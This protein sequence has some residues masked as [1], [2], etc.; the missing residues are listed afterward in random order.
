M[1]EKFHFHKRLDVLHYGCEEPRA[2]FVPYHSESAAKTDNRAESRFFKTLCGE[3]DFHF[4]SS[5]LDLVDFTAPSCKVNYDKIPV[6][7][8]WQYLTDRGYDVPNYTNV[9]YPFP[10]DP[11]H[12][13]DNNPC[14][15]YHRTFTIS[16]SVLNTKDTFLVFE[17]VDSCFYVFVNNEFVAYSQVAHMT[18]E[19]DITPYIKHGT[20]DLKVLVFKWCD[21]SYLECQDKWR[22]SGIIREVYLLSRDKE[23][24]Q[25][26]FVKYELDDLYTT[27]HLTTDI[28]YIGSPDM[29]WTLTDVNNNIVAQG[30]QIIDAVIDH[31]I[32]WNDEDPYL[33]TLMIRCG[34]E[35]IRQSIGFRNFTTENGVMLINDKPVK[36]KGVNR[37]DSHPYLGSATPME[38]MLGDILIMKQNNVN[39]VRTSHYPNDPRFA[40]LCDQYG[41]Y[42]IDEADLETHGM[43]E[44]GDGAYTA[45]HP[46]WEEAY[47]DRARRMVERDK[48]HASILM[49]SLGNESD[50]GE[51][52]RHMARWIRHRDTSRLIHYEG[53]NRGRHKEEI[54]KGELLLDVESRMY[55]S[56]QGM[57]E[58]LKDKG[59]ILP[60]FQCEYCHAMG[61]GPGDLKE[62]WDVI[63][64]SDR[65]AGGCIWE[66]LDHSVA[67]PDDH[68]KPRFTYGGDFGDTPNDGNFCVDGL[69]YP[70]RRLHT[71]ML[72]AKQIYAPL[73]ISPENLAEG[74]FKITSYRYFT[75]LSDLSVGYTI[76]K[77]GKVIQ[78]ETLPK[79]ATA[80]CEEA[81][82]KIDL[83]ENLTGRVFVTFTVKQAVLTDW[84]SLDHELCFYQFEIPAEEEIVTPDDPMYSLSIFEKGSIITISSG[85]I[86]YTFDRRL[87]LLTGIEDNGKML[88]T[89]PMMPTVWRAPLDNDRNIMNHWR[90][91]GYHRAFTKVYSV[92][93][94]IYTDTSVSWESTLALGGFINRPILKTRILYTV[95]L[96]GELTV[97]QKITVDNEYPFLPRYGMRIVMP[98]QS[99]RMAFFGMGP[100]EAYAD[101]HLSARMGLY[102]STVSENFEP[103]V[104]PQENSA[105]VGTEWAAVWS[106]AGHG[107]LFASNATFTFNAQHYSAEMLTETKHDYEL[108]PDKR[109][110]VYIDYKQSGSGSNSCGPGLA[111][112]YRFNEKEFEFTFSLKPVFANDIDFFKESKKI[113]Q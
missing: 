5:S 23:R 62:Y 56:P 99:E 20:N 29:V 98:E 71:G 69:V 75:D 45:N 96:T 102:R 106:Y 66:M 37:H 16:D 1:I 70:D 82:V 104:K 43:Y 30:S 8:S 31:P 86:T 17:G 108:I 63:R 26:F 50:Y 110:F 78:K 18:S 76:E 48:N 83:P 28:E 81:E 49:W 85:E 89:E 55:E 100:K 42:M 94:L 39:T 73:L 10:C 6:P 9:V 57:L 103:Y 60:F 51:N 44:T 105:H 7:M 15:L 58:Y 25:D 38:S 27:A 36:L 64:S 59:N 84:A 90:G 3:W 93:D 79:L 11:P 80:P 54:A 77:N 95:T 91:R 14:G 113:T 40:S 109:T 32:L 61:N 24:I 74:L 112:K 34:D 107:L 101:K 87:G 67:L 68:L 35:Y 72:E 19:I 88:L 21:G 2:Y 111:E 65:F 53:C 97:S 92:S 13:P 46:D 22:T 4:F 33:Y 12:V 47:I 52:H 41:I